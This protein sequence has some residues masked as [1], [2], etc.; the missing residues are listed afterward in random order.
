MRMRRL[1]AKGIVGPVVACG[2][3]LMNCGWCTAYR[4]A[5]RRDSGAQ[6][7]GGSG[8]DLRYLVVN[9]TLR[10]SH[11]RGRDLQT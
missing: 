9:K 5:V 10:P 4:H 2:L 3:W 6:E 11:G 7:T 8:D 1:R